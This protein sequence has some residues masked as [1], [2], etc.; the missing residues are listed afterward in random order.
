M[1]MFTA[2]IYLHSAARQHNT[3]SFGVCALLLDGVLCVF[4]LRYPLSCVFYETINRHSYLMNV[5]TL[6]STSDDSFAGRDLNENVEFENEGVRCIRQGS[7]S[8]EK[9]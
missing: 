5:S 3:G 4:V 8:R 1:E 7:S 6:T 2:A 9:Y